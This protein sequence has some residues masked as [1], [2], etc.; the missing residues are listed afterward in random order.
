MNNKKINKDE[1]Y[2]KYEEY[3]IYNK[4][5]NDI[6]KERKKYNNKND[7][8]LSLN[9]IWTLFFF[10]LIIIIPFIIFSLFTS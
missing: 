2:K 8:L 6:K 1:L 5:K 4:V 7:N 3:L 9:I 10:M